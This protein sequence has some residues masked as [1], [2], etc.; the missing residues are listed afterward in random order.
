MRKNT[1]RDEA[2][3]GNDSLEDLVYRSRLTAG[4]TRVRSG[5]PLIT[6]PITLLGYLAL[7]FLGWQLVQHSRT[8][9]KEGPKSVVVDLQD[10]S[11]GDAPQ[12]AAPAPLPAAGG[13]PPGAIEKTD[14]PP[15]P[16]PV[17]PDTVPEKPPAE[18]PTQDLSGVAVPAQGPGGPGGTGTGPGTGEGTGPGGNGTG[19]GPLVLHY[20]NS[21]VKEK[22][23]PPDPPYPPFAKMAR[24]QGT[25]SIQITVGVDGVPVS[26]HATEGPMQLRQAAEVYAMKWRFE[27]VKENGV[28]VI[29]TWSLKVSFQ[30]R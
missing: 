8:L 14:A 25:V 29:G 30:L 12:T 23:R 19:Q 15:M 7:G 27:P 18:L 6:L 10:L 4:G 28:P 5:N 3:G 11:E 21:P 13:P 24:I 1:S 9:A 22:Y 26:A 20:E 16:V 17:T 2:S